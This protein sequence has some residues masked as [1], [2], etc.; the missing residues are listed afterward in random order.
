MPAQVF[1]GT[2]V[3][4][5]L[6]MFSVIFLLKPA[7]IFGAWSEKAGAAITFLG[8]FFLCLCFCWSVILGGILFM[9]GFVV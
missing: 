5:F 8:M 2:A 3:E 4:F 1:L 6:V 7:F 9:N